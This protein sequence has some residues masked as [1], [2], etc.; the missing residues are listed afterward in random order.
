VFLLTSTVFAFYDVVVR[1]RQKKVMESATRTNDIV[2]A[3]FPANVR[4]RMYRHAISDNPVPQRSSALIQ[5]RSEAQALQPGCREAS[6]FGSQ[7]IA[8]FFPSATV[9]F[10]DIANFT[11][12]C[13]ERDPTQVFT[14]LENL[15]HKFDRI[16]QEHGIFKVET[17]GDSYVAVAGVPAPRQDHAVAIARFAS[18]CLRD[19]DQIVKDL[20]T[21]LGPSTGDLQA[22]VGLHSG[23]VTAGVLRGTKARF[24]LFGDTVNTAARMESQGRPNMIHA[25][26]E[27]V[28]QLREAGLDAWTSP[29]DEKIRVK[30]KGLLQTFWVDIGT[31]SR[32]SL[33]N[34]Y[35][36]STSTM[37]ND[38]VFSVSTKTFMSST[39][40]G[41]KSKRT[42]RLINWN[43]S[44]LYAIL[45]KLSAARMATAK[46]NKNRK[47]RITSDSMYRR[48]ANAAENCTPTPAI[49][50]MTQ[51]IEIPEFDPG[52]Y[53]NVQPIELDPQIKQQ[54]FD[55]VADIS[56]RYRD[57][58]FHNF[59]H[60][61]HVVMSASKLMKR[62][63]L[64]DG[65]DAKCVQENGQPDVALARDVH[66][67]TYGLSSDL[68]L[69]FAV[70]F[71]GLIHDVDHTGLTNK[72]LS[73]IDD[74]LAIAYD[75]KCVAE[76]NSVQIAW[77]I[78]MEDKYAKLR[79]CIFESERDKHRFREL[80][81]D[82]VLATD[83]ADK[84]LGTLRKNRWDDAF[85]SPAEGNDTS[86]D[87]NRKATIVFEHIIQAS[88]VSHC[89]QHW[90]TYQRFNA[91]LFEERYLAYRKGVAGENPPWVGWYK[92][93]IWFFDNYILPLARKLKEC[94][95]FG[96]S[97]D[98]FLNYAQ[99]NRMEWER[100]G[101]EIVQALRQKMEEKYS[102]GVAT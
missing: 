67:I 78:L 18:Q 12:W 4:D 16:G 28:L 41:E 5:S 48:T 98:E 2:T 61:S 1:R 29:R 14:L 75:K 92:G 13:S 52:M 54:L 33:D 46:Y 68:L 56:E 102:V 101:N 9:A 70:V 62:I 82:S 11:S 76:Q 80:V 86:L 65:I 8:D 55:F 37:S 44:Q 74:P 71:S 81:V 93:E 7:P 30:G 40:S 6:V 35:R 50:E 47:T 15:Y 49:A 10:I 59:E 97:Y 45:E 38:V 100:E 23:P 87:R 19:M 22:R 77:D 42:L 89:M 32:R 27:T 39:E 99:E 53:H 36:L 21:S 63:I 31:Q 58:P 85:S 3:L 94:G 84:E 43:V 24:Q 64:P 72:E 73:D 17:I 90:H 95:V 79:E 66:R 51:I 83:I 26:L 34:P 69:Q 60:A 96:V 25:T 20:E 91:R 88:D 57:V